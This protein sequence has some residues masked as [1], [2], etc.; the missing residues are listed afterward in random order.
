MIWWFCT[1]LS[2]MLRIGVESGVIFWML[3]EQ[4][5]VCGGV[6]VTK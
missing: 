5:G 3:G 4:D 2:K 1:S 6:D